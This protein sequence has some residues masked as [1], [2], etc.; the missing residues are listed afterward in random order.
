MP[1]QLLPVLERW[2]AKTPKTASGPAVG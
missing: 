2:L 1:E